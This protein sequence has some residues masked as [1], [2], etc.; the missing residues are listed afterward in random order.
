M[1]SR[2]GA[3]DP[4]PFNPFLVIL[5]PDL[6]ARNPNQGEEVVGATPGH[7]GG[8]GGGGRRPHGGAE[9]MGERVSLGH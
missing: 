4:A 1:V 9:A 2:P 3:A 7:Q 6:V 8:G 5:W